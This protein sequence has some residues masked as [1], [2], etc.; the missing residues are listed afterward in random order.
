MQGKEVA[1]GDVKTDVEDDRGGARRTKSK[2][3]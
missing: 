1:S 2:I 3:L